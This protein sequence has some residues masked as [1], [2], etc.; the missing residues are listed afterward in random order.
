MLDAVTRRSLAAAAALLLAAAWSCNQPETAPTAGPHAPPTT[1]I[2]AIVISGVSGSARVGDR[3]TLKA[4]ASLSDGTT[5]DVTAQARWESSDSAIAAVS[6]GGELS[7]LA[8]G[9]VDIRA[10]YQ[11]ARS[12]IH[13]AVAPLV[14]TVT[15]VAIGGV[16]AAIAAGEQASLTASAILSDG[17]SENVTSAATWQSSNT[18]VA[19]VSPIGELTTLATGDV[20][21]HATYRGVDGSVHLSVGPAQR[22]VLSGIVADALTGRPVANARVELFGGPNTGRVTSSDGSGFY[23]FGAL[24][25]GSFTIDVSANGYEHTLTHV[26]LTGDTVLNLPA[27]PISPVTSTYAITF[28]KVQDTC[29]DIT[30]GPTGQLTLSGT[31]VNLSIQV[32]ERGIL[33]AYEGFLTADGSFV[34]TG[35]GTTTSPARGAWRVLHDYGGSIKGKVNGNAIS[36]TETLTFTTGCNGFLIVAFTGSR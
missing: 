34:G 17:T 3:I 5:Q 36:G 19:Q 8:A 29:G 16:P 12:S 31:T 32:L 9:E 1:T 24:F 21:I 20:D 30:P 26:T 4:T 13:I 6:P 2:G 10:S 15:R 14:A 18:V 27:R 25:K 33:R 35:V 22:S 7:A 28:T 23:D 11:D